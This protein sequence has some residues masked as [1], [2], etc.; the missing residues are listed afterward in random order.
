[1]SPAWKLRRGA[2]SVKP[3]LLDKIVFGTIILTSVV[4]MFFLAPKVRHF[5]LLTPFVLVT[6]MTL[7]LCVAAFL[8]IRW[9][10]WVWAVFTGTGIVLEALTAGIALVAPSLF[11]R[12]DHVNG[13][14]F[15]VQSL[16][17]AYVVWRLRT[18]KQLPA[19][20]VA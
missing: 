12:G 1:M 4:D 20:N 19:P 13:F 10:F 3:E 6:L 16:E 7:L 14:T 18:W 17:F 8:S 9:A 2:P 5:F 11:P 15:L